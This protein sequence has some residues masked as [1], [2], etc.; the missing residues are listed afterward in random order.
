MTSQKPSNDLRRLLVVL[1]ALLV[2]VLVVSGVMFYFELFGNSAE[3]ADPLV[4]EET[5]DGLPSEPLA[6]G[7]LGEIA[8]GIHVETGF[9]VGDGLEIV[10]ANCTPCHSSKLVIQNRAT[11]EGWESI[12]RWMQETQNLWELGSNQPIILDYLVRN[13]APEAA[14][15]RANLKNI[16]WYELGD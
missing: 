2:I 1:A 6:V 10:I 16:E 5:I 11:R 4:Q 14:G 9:K 7:S 3:S 13:Y 8:D 12:I 15:R